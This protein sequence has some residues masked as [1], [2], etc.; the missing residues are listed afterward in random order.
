MKNSLLLWF[1]LS[2]AVASAAPSAYVPARHDFQR[3]PVIAPSALQVDVAGR[4]M[5]PAEYTQSRS[6]NGSWKISGLVNA[7]GPFAAEVDLDLAYQQADFDD[8]QW[9]DIAVPLD[10]F[11][12]YRQAYQREQ[13]YVKGWYRR[14]FELSAEDL[15][16]RRVILH[17]ER[18]GYEALLF[19]NGQEVGRH[20][21]DFT[22]YEVD[23]TEA[24]R[25]G[26]N[27]LAMRVLTDFGPAFGRK[28][29]V[30]HSYGSQWSM[31]NIRGGIW[32]DATLRLEPLVRIEQLLL[33]PLPRCPGH[34][35]D[36]NAL[37]A[38]YVVRNHS[39]VTSNVRLLGVLSSAMQADAAAGNITQWSEQI[40]DWNAREYRAAG[41]EPNTHRGQLQLVLDNAIPLQLWQL[42]R[43]YL[44]FFTLLVLDEQNQVLA[45]RSERFGF[46]RFEVR[47]GKFYLNGEEVYLFGE[48]IPSASFGGSG[49]SA[50]DLEARL[51]TSIRNERN[52]G[53][54][55]LRNAHMPILPIALTIADEL[56]MM[57]FNEWAWCF[58]AAIDEEP[59]AR[60]NLREVRQF[61]V[62]S[63]NYPSVCM[64]S[65]G[66]EVRHA[67][68]PDIW[69]Q[70]NAQV[71]LVRELDGQGRPI[72]N[73]SGSASW[74]SYGRD[75][76]DT[77]VLDLHTYV[78]LSNP[79]TQ[80]DSQSNGNY[81][82]L[83]EIYGEQERLSRPLVAWENIG[84]SWGWKSDKNFR[85]G[86]VEDYL[87]YAKADT[88]WGQPNGIG[89]TGAIGLSEAILPGKSPAMPMNMYGRRIL[90]LYRL[91]RRYTGFAPWYNIE[92]LECAPLWN[93][94]V[95]PTLH[96]ERNFPPR[97]LYAGESSEWICELVNSGNASYRDLT[98]SME[99]V[100]PEDENR[101]ALG[102]WVIP[103]LPAQANSAQPQRL[104]LPMVPAGSYQ[105]RLTLLDSAGQRIGQNFYDLTL[106]QR[107]ELTRPIVPR[108]PVAVLD[109]G[110]PGNLAALCKQ[111]DAFAVPYSVVTDPDTVAAGTVLVLPPEI[112]SQ[113]VAPALT[114]ALER[115]VHKGGIFLALEQQNMASKLPGAYSVSL[116]ETSFCDMVLPDH[117]V[118]ANMTLRHVDT[119][120]D[121]KRCMV[122]NSAYR[123]F[124]VNAVAARG[125]R[126]GQKNVGM[127]LVEGTSGGGRVIYSQLLAFA[128]LE[129]DSAAALF[130]R[131]LFHYAFAS[132]EWWE[133]SYKLVPAQLMAY[134][135]KAERALQVDLRAAVNRSFSDEE[136][137]DGAG[138]WTD[139]GS[140]DFR[141][142]PLG[143]KTFVGVPFT[144]I[145]PASNDDKSCIVLAGSDRPNFPLAAKGIPLQG[146]FSRL[147]FL[148]TAAWGAADKVGRYRMHY[149][150]GSIAE[151]PLRGNHNIGDWW[152]NA[153]LPQAII[154]LSEKNP[155]GQRVCLYV[156]E[157]INPRPTLPLL[158]LDFLSPLYSDEHDIDYLPGRTGVP[159][160][161]AVTA[162]R[163]HPQR[164]EILGER[165]RSCSGTKDI[166]SETVGAVAQIELDGRRAWQVDFPAVPTGDVPVVFFGFRVDQSAL[167]EHYDY[168][169]L[170]IKSE[171]SVSVMVSL[172]E[173]SWK[174][175]LSGNLTLIGDGQFHDYRLRIG[176]DLRAGGL[177][178]YPGMRGELFF[179][180][181]VQGAN[182]RERDAL[183]FVISD[184]VLE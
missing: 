106:Q 41:E 26:K 136:D 154:G 161:V 97:H 113:T 83:L 111:L 177:F 101:R 47:N 149:A 13:P 146:S 153:P 88:S 20:L 159:V 1:G 173:K 125:P 52:N 33:D 124:T 90:E 102:S 19:V 24:L 169:S 76:L 158:A 15:R 130:L 168:V 71:A 150:D 61:V 184:A 112:A 114:Q 174:A 58:T 55:M 138:G 21:G 69:R 181:K 145:D 4:T 152:N 92:T 2:V 3:V 12:H 82:G 108:R 54:V 7:A 79:W 93:Q 80:R 22:E 34:E 142:M 35:Q 143:D 45:A 36:P 110:A 167:A 63:Y 109:S 120:D 183:R 28:E 50:A 131:N 85:V 49:E 135:V 182:S 78:A 53:Y 72:S 132:K 59:F 64:W 122:V 68:R 170:R 73:F 38:S 175:T 119:W 95:L 162:E 10:W 134:T 123:P 23:V 46:R 66:N 104:E 164:Y 6:L 84:F 9:D 87:K 96:S 165:Y 172:P 74:G 42:D 166:G 27:S 129:R 60:Q 91:D 163:A 179:Y 29:P 99:L 30:S 56:G 155:S 107:A 31:S 103:A 11:R 14:H 137:G 156:S 151:L 139:Q 57:I 51:T 171:R 178:S 40:V 118:F 32:G 39:G 89:F 37:R 148:H 62:D 176:E 140:N 126:L 116:G 147:F 180:Y 5:R 98:L 44:Y 94:L 86:N 141:M 115:F 67:G 157:W 100:G 65:M 160:L 75:P 17:F 70:L 16:N 8:S 25:P 43:P 127:A 133:Q 121:G 18:I 77:D 81:Q 105:L 48:N 128:A 117:P 144:I